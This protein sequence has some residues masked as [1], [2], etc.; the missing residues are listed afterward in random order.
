MNKAELD[1]MIIRRIM[2]YID[3]LDSFGNWDGLYMDVEEY[4]SEDE[5]TET[6]HKFYKEL[7]TLV[8]THYES[9]Q[10]NE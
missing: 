5:I 10:N 3:D 4:F 2:Y 1:E 8:K 7:E 6:I 9:R